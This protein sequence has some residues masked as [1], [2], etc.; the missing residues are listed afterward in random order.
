MVDNQ[1]SNQSFLDL[2]VKVFQ[3]KTNGQLSITIPRK[4]TKDFLANGIPNKMP[5]RIYWGKK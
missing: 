4:K 2:K 1:K 3:N 5:I